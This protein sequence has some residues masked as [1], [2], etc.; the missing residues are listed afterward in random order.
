MTEKRGGSHGRANT[1]KAYPQAD[2]SDEIVGHKWFC[3]APMCDAW[4]VL[5]YVEAGLTCFL[6]PK[7]RP[8]GSRNPIRIQRLKDKL[9]DWSNAS[10]EVEF[11]GA[12]AERV[13]EEGRG[14][15]TILQMVALTR[16]LG[17]ASCRERVCQYV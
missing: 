1:T 10:S 15:S 9:G 2:G 14:V 7:M 5:A 13:G 11:L 3:S 4:L 12:W 8:D 6:M 17:R 16:Q